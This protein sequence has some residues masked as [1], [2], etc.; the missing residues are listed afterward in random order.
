MTDLIKCISNEIIPDP[1]T[2]MRSNISLIEQ[3]TIK[4]AQISF[5]N[6]LFINLKI[7]Y[8]IKNNIKIY[9]DCITNVLKTKTL[10]EIYC[11]IITYLDISDMFDNKILY[12]YD[13]TQEK[14]S[15]LPNITLNHIYNFFI[16]EK[17]FNKSELD[18][19]KNKISYKDV[20]CT[21]YPDIYRK[22][23]TELKMIDYALNEIVKTSKI[24]ITEDYLYIWVVE[25][26]SILY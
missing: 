3:N 13:K 26:L 18:D 8:S 5:N 25:L 4:R 11:K 21:V 9:K 2:L 16:N 20:C 22:K 23:R 10:P 14:L 7:H 12:K 6:Y 19:I 15:M 1:P 24:N 17:Y